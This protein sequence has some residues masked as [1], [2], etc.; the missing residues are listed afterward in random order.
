MKVVIQEEDFDIQ[1][2]IGKI[3]REH[4]DIGALVSF[5]GLVRDFSEH[6][7]V[8]EM[9]LEHYPGMTEK[10]LEAILHEAKARWKIED[11][12]V[13]HRVGRLLARDQI[14]LVLVASHHRKDAFRAAEFVID[15]LKTEAPFWKKENTPEGW[16]WVDA[17]NSDE[18]ASS[19]WME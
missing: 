5:I 14:V 13:I 8:T 9:M 18:A 7:K 12:T 2:E 16:H 10:S 19:E 1:E 4:A 6:S 15:R 3:R 17:K 11:A